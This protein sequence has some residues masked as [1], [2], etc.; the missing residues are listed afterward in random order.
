MQ[1]WRGEMMHMGHQP[2]SRITCPVRCKVRVA[3][4]A[5]AGHAVRM[6]PALLLV[7]LNLP[8]SCTPLGAHPSWWWQTG[9]G[10]APAGGRACRCTAQT[11]RLAP[12]RWCSRGHRRSLQEVWLGWAAHWVLDSLALTICQ[13]A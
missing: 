11:A 9:R 10:A 1:L 5:A 3:D 6:A 7:N 13:L 4:W 2:L 8:P 12:H